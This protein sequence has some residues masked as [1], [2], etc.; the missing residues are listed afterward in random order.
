MKFEQL[1]DGIYVCD[2]T[3]EITIPPTKIIYGQWFMPSALRRAEFEDICARFVERSRSANQW[4]AVSYSRLGS[5][6]LSELKDQERAENRIAGKHLGPLRR[7]YKKLKGEKPAEVEESKLPFS[8]IRTMI[9]LTG[10]DVL[11]RELRSMEDKRYL[12]V[13]ERDDESLLVPTQAMIETAYNAQ[14][15]ARKE[16]KD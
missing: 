13:V 2:T 15:R 3:K 12:N 10:P 6:L 16:K 8:V 4:V 14:E 9:A 7:L 1:E 5:E 11:P